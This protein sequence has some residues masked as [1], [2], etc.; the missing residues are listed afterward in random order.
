MTEIIPERFLNKVEKTNKCWLWKAMKDKNGYGIFWERGKHVF[1]HRYIFKILNESLEDALTIDHLCRV[2]SCVNPAHLEAVTIGQNVLRGIGIAAINAKKTEC[3][4]GHPFSNQ[5]T[6]RK[7]NGP[8]NC[9][10]CTNIGQN[11]RYL[12]KKGMATP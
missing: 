9:R 1:A 6:I 3:K 11:S 2:H 7:K 4:R 5:N 8:R 10:I 12:K